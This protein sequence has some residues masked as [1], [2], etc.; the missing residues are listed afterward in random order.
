MFLSPLT[1]SL[2]ALTIST[3]WNLHPWEFRAISPDLEESF[4]ENGVIHPILVM[5][6][7][8]D[9]Y[10]LVAGARR[11]E[12]IRKSL[13]PC[14]INCLVLDEDTPHHS[15]LHL[16][17]AD[18][19]SFS[20]LTLAEKARFI[21]I[22]LHYLKLEEIITTF[23][24]KLQLKGGRSS[25]SILQKILQQDDQIIREIHA[26]RLQERMLSEIFSLPDMTDRVALVQLFTDL[27]LGES[28][29]RKFFSLLRD[30]AWQQGASIASYIDKP[31]IRQ[32]L[33]H[34]E[35]NIPQKIQHLGN[36]LQQTIAPASTRAEEAFQRQV[37]ELHLPKN[38]T[39]AHS[40]SFEKDQITLSITFDDMADCKEYLS[41]LRRRT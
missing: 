27:R 26:G 19:S 11:L 8:K 18:Q 32:I 3:K 37:K 17:L 25:F 30:I 39:I 9:S 23:Q 28:K 13:N 15:L 20:P 12:F 10:V 40:P 36:L 29:Q 33:E 35:M 24:D 31:E 41:Q 38:H 4:T 21:E 5:R 1:I 34:K 22:A 6:V 16:I 2:D 7:S 14:Q